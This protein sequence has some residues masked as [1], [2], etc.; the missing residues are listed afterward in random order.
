MFDEKFESAKSP[1]LCLKPVKS[2]DRTAIPFALSAREIRTA[3][4]DF[5]VQV[6]QWAKIA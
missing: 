5:L 3:A 4:S 1:P 2:K 6:K